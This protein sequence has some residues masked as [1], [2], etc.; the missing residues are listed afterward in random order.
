[1]LYGALFLILFH[2]SFTTLL[3]YGVFIAIGYPLLLVPYLSLTYDVI[4]R[5]RHARKARI[6]YIVLRE[7]FLN[8][9]RIVSILFFLIIVSLLKDDVG[10]PVSLALLGAG[11]TL[12]YYFVK[13][14]RFTE[15]DPAEETMAEDGQKRVAEPNLLKG[16]R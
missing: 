15:P 13:D 3:T 10:I 12:I 1:M 4:G 8:A 7:L 9:G 14:I 6:E 16:E 11:H 2:M 5:A